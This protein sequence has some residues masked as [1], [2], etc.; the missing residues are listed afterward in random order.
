MNQSIFFSIAVLLF[1]SCFVVTSAFAREES[2]KVQVKETQ[3]TAAEVKDS[4]EVGTPMIV[5]VA[6]GLGKDAEEDEHIPEIVSEEEV[7][8]I[9]DANTDTIPVGNITHATA[10]VEFEPHKEKKKST[11]KS[12][13]II[14]DSFEDAKDEKTEAE[15]DIEEDVMKSESRF[16]VPHFIKDLLKHS[17][18]QGSF[19]GAYELP[20]VPDISSIFGD[21]PSNCKAG[22]CRPAAGPRIE[23]DAAE[24]TPVQPMTSMED[25]TKQIS[26]IT[27]RLDAKKFLSDG[28]LEDEPTK[29]ETKQKEDSNIELK[30]GEIERHL[31]DNQGLQ[32]E[33]SSNLE[34]M[35]SLL[36]LR[37]KAIIDKAKSHLKETIGS[38]S[39]LLDELHEILGSLNALER[40]MTKSLH[41]NQNL[42]SDT[43]KSQLNEEQTVD[44]SSPIL[45]DKSHEA[46]PSIELVKAQDATKTVQST[47]EKPKEDKK[48]DEE[49]EEKKTDKA[50]EKKK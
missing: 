3:E 2:G 39:N 41:Q 31:M 29:N 49:K 25:L 4:S 12:N 40:A 5:R 38:Q 46:A 16:E 42:L 47:E 28:M 6:E 22:G 30:I 11:E 34:Q 35:T 48:T 19:D 18:E 32:R 36:R 45:E 43:V 50:V 9:K 37:K 24:S 17:T 15:S 1:L 26:E 8:K 23:R 44:E 10:S 21:L 13:V 7:K 14:V 27:D 33:L 20:P